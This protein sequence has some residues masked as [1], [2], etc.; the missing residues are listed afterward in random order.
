MKKIPLEKVI[1]AL[2]LLF[3][4]FI[5]GFYYGRNSGTSLDMTAHSVR[6]Y[7]EKES[8]DLAVSSQST[9]DSDETASNEVKDSDTTEDVVAQLIHINSASVSE[10]MSLPGIGETLAN[11]IVSYRETHGDFTTTEELMEVDGIGEKKY[12]AI[13]AYITVEE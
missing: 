7:T 12:A 9:F 11:R 4:C 2:T 6:V 13:E 3:A 5:A 8:A 1:L 10:L